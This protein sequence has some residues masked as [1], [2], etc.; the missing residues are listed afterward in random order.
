MITIKPEYQ[1]NNKLP[2]GTG[3]SP[4]S[5]TLPYSSLVI[6]TTNGKAGSSFNAELNYLINS[7]D[8]SA[9]YIVSKTGDI[10]QM[11]DPMKFMA[12]HTGK[13]KDITKYGNPHAIG[14]EVHFSPSEGVWTGE[15]W[16]AITELARLYI[17]LEKV[18]HRGIAIPPGRKIDPSGISD[19]GFNYWAKNFHRP[20]SIYK[21]TSN[22]NIRE[23]PTRDS[24]ILATIK[25]DAT[26]FSFNG[27]VVFGESIDENNRWRF[28][29]SLGYIYEPLL[30]TKKF[31]E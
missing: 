1:K 25:Q 9:H 10:V 3:Y 6:H 28:V 2:P 13:T 31:V 16:D 17:R 29:N 23:S 21:A 8:V 27:D 12:W 11:L 26:V 19:D 7:P 14:V 24:K 22:A 4:R 15:M 30:A 20:Y 5:Q 18:T